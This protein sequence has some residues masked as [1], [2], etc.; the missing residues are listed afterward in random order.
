MSPLSISDLFEDVLGEVLSATRFVDFEVPDLQIYKFKYVRF[1]L[2]K[3]AGSAVPVPALRCVCRRW[4]RVLGL[5]YGIEYD[6]YLRTFLKAHRAGIY[7]AT[8]MAIRSLSQC[9]TRL[10]SD[11]FRLFVCNVQP[12]IDVAV[13]YSHYGRSELV[14]LMAL[15]QSDTSMKG[16]LHYRTMSGLLSSHVARWLVYAVAYAENSTT[17]LMHI[18]LYLWAS[19]TQSAHGCSILDRQGRIGVMM[20]MQQNA[21]LLR[22]LCAEAHRQ[23]SALQSVMETARD[24]DRH[25]GYD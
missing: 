25:A 24:V 18:R 11:E 17:R 6:T 12:C 20:V 15:M 21:D 14:S 22:Q 3:F 8:T 7:Y 9:V 16:R 2:G 4:K 13:L 5:S 10:L 23:G 19:E 1:D